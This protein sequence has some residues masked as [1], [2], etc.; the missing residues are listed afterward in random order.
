[1][2]TTIEISDSLLD[3][4]K[5][6]AA[7]EGTTI[8]AYVEQG[9]RRIVAERK[10]RG[11]FRLRKATFKGKGLQPGVKDATWERI[12]EAIYQGRGG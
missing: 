3:E 12:R 6:L 11:Q 4:A 10:S 1:M 8:R 7:K 5:K 9:L 2:K